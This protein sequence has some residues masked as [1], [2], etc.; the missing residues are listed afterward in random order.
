[1]GV[2]GDAF[3]LLRNQLYCKYP[4]KKSIPE[5]DLYGADL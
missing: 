2:I 5:I 1:M 4:C 3:D